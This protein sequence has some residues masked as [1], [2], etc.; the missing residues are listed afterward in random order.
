MKIHSL[1]SFSTGKIFWKA[2]KYSLFV[3]FQTISKKGEGKNFCGKLFQKVDWLPYGQGS[4]QKS[5]YCTFL[6]LKKTFRWFYK[7]A[8]VWPASRPLKT[9]SARDQAKPSESE[10]A[11]KS[12]RRKEGSLQQLFAKKEICIHHENLDHTSNLV[13]QVMKSSYQI[14]QCFF[15]F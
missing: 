3:T 7:P 4:W 14:S 9:V 8:I 12:K 15:L 6:F 13:F 5:P 11:A 10:L 2:M 1:V